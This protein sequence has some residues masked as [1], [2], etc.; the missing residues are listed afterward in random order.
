MS[1]SAVALQLKSENLH[2]GAATVT[3]T[4]LK[5]LFNCD[6]DSRQQPP[7]RLVFHY[8]GSNK[9]RALGLVQ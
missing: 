2:H 7:M 6:A 8:N 5:R 3:N 1:R 9:Q 4:Y